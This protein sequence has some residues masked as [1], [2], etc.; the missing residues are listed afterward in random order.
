MTRDTDSFGRR[1]AQ[2]TSVATL[3]DLE[4]REN[5]TER[6]AGL[7]SLISELL[8]RSLR[9]ERLVTMTENEVYENSVAVDGLSPE[10]R[11][12]LA[13]SFSLER[14]QARGAWFVPDQVRLE[15]G[16]TNFPFFLMQGFRF[17][18]GLASL[19]R[20]KVLLKSSPDAIFL[21]SVLEPLFEAF[22][23]PFDLRGKLSGTLSSEAHRAAWR[24]VDVLFNDLGFPPLAE[25]SLLRGGWN[26]LPD[27]SSQL[28][29]KQQL[30]RALIPAVDPT[31]GTRYRL[32][33]C[34]QLIHQYYKKAV[35]DGRAKR[36]QVLTK[37]FQPTLSGFF[38]G[39]W[40]GLLD[41]LG[42]QPHAEEEILTAIPKTP[43]KVRGANRAAEIAASEGI[44]AE[45]VHRIAAALWSESGG[46]SPIEARI[47]ALKRLWWVFDDIHEK[48]RSGMKP[49][50]GLVEES[51]WISLEPEADSPYQPGLYRDLLPS[52]LI[53]DIE[54]LWG[55]IMFTRWPERIV[56]EAFPHRLMAETFGPA[57]LFWQSCALTAWFLCEGPRSVT[58]MAG[59][60]HHQR[61]RLHDLKEMKT[62]V[63]ERLFQD[64]IKAEH[65]LGPPERI[66]TNTSATDVGYG[67]SVTTSI[68]AGSR[69][70]GFDMLRD[71]VTRHR[72]VWA[73]NYLDSYLHS[74][75]ES[76]IREAAKRFTLALSEKGGKAP[77][78]KQFASAAGPPTN[79][80]FGGDVSGLYRTIGEKSPVEPERRILMPADKVSFVRRVMEVLPSLQFEVYDGR[81]SDDAT[82]NSYRKELAQLAIKYVQL[83]EALGR[84]PQLKEI[85]EK[86]A[87]RSKVLSDDLSQAWS[88]YETAVRK[89][90]IA[91]GSEARAMSSIPQLLSDV[92]SE[93]TTRQL[94]PQVARPIEKAAEKRSWLDRIFR[95]E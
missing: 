88:I 93:T 75:W 44:P 13:E 47:A 16:G 15:G 24:E 54:S 89:A 72:R 39:N 21:W 26:E 77:T 45:E 18:H 41:Y 6:F 80:W 50:W 43:L 66:T 60:A 95:R 10:Q 48:Q 4:L 25:M 37:T 81:I 74:R 35:T 8:I 87:Y 85:G 56:T 36:K 5:R 84:P 22:L 34:R 31:T 49:L 63:D 69:R 68:I 61:R 86:F 64:L 62:P 1:A 32:H 53:A 57:L 51:E 73:N 9:G 17:P 11:E 92:R 28:A 40:L 58:D 3:I 38:Q 7:D 52:D 2:A 30:M 79:H 12:F 90:R 78:L 94:S 91:V 65:R 55:T 27:A 29:A 14:Q 82:Q 59:L 20:G 83:E 23:Y 71:I 76:E 33:R 46:V 19:E 70:K 67:M 42:E